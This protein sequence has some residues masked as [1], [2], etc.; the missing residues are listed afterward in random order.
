MQQRTSKAG[1]AR[2]DHAATRPE[3]MAAVRFRNGRRELF[4]VRNA[5]DLDDAR[6]VVLAELDDVQAVVIA[7]HR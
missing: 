6:A 4:R 2:A 7:P 5:D 1:G 3:F